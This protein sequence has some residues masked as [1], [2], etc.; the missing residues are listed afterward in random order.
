M[1]DITIKYQGREIPVRSVTR[2]Q[3]R[4]L[5]NLNKMVYAQT[6]FKVVD[7]KPQII[8][9]NTDYNLLARMYELAL[10]IAFDDLEVLDAEYN[11]TEQDIIA[12]KCV[13]L[14]L[15]LPKKKN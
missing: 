2:A 14:Y 12:Q 3:R 6:E 11:D 8:N 5:H 1:A 7:D 4:E 13:S 15:K 9:L 10:S